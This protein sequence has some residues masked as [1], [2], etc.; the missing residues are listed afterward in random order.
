M[1]QKSDQEFDTSKLPFVEQETIASQPV[2]IF[3]DYLL[4]LSK[5]L[6]QPRRLLQE[7]YEEGIYKTT[8]SNVLSSYKILI[9]LLYYILHGTY[10]TPLA[11]QPPLLKQGAIVPK[12]IINALEVETIF[13]YLSIDLGFFNLFALHIPLNPHKNKYREAYHIFT[14]FSET[15]TPFTAD[16]MQIFKEIAHFHIRNLL[17]FSSFGGARACTEHPTLFLHFDTY[18]QTIAKKAYEY[19]RAPDNGSPYECFYPITPYKFENLHDRQLEKEVTRIVAAEEKRLTRFIHA[20]METTHYLATCYQQTEKAHSLVSFINTEHYLLETI[21]NVP[22]NPYYAFDHKV[23]AKKRKADE[24]KSARFA[25]ELAREA[26]V[27]RHKWEIEYAL[28]QSTHEIT[29]T[30]VIS[31]LP[32]PS[33]PTILGYE[34]IEGKRSRNFVTVTD[35]LR[36]AGMYMVGVGGTGKSSE[37]EALVWQDI[38]K[39][40]GVIVLDPH[41]QLI[42]NII[43]RMPEQFLQKTYFFDLADET[44]MFGLNIFSCKDIASEKERDKAFGGVKVAFSKLFPEADKKLFGTTLR[45][46][47][48]T[49]IENP[50]MTLQ[51][52]QRFIQDEAYREEKIKH[53]HHAQTR[54]YWQQT[55]SAK[56]PSKQQTETDP[57]LNRVD[58]LLSSNPIRRALCQ[59]ATS[60]DFRQAIENREIILVR[61]PMEEDEYRE[62]GSILGTILVSKIKSATFS[63][64]DLDEKVIPGFSLYIDEFQNFES[65]DMATLYTQARKYGVRLCLAHQT[66]KGQITI[67][68]IRA[69]T[70]SATTKLFFRSI[71]ADSRELAGSI[72]NLELKTRPDNI[73]HEVLK[74]LPY[75]KHWK[76]QNFAKYTVAPLQRWQGKDD[77]L[78][79]DRR[80]WY[81]Y[82]DKNNQTV[83]CVNRTFKE[84]L[85]IIEV[86]LRD[87]MLK[88]EV[89]LVKRDEIINVFAVRWGF[90]NSF[91]RYSWPFE[92]VTKEQNLRVWY[93]G[94]DTPQVNKGTE[95]EKL[96][97]EALTVEQ[98]SHI[99]FLE[100][101]KE[102]AEILI[103]DPIG[104]KADTTQDERAN[105]LSNL[106]NRKV[107]AKIESKTFEMETRDLDELS[108]PVPDY[109]RDTRIDRIIDQTHRD[110]CK[111]NSMIDAYLNRKEQSVKADTDVE[112]EEQQKPKQQKKSKQ[113]RPQK[114]WGERKPQRSE[115]GEDDDE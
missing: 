43:A 16:E 88:Q 86:F 20:F 42:K 80:L 82:E 75:Y 26:E 70:I 17:F 61:L 29:D 109:E 107:V 79:G 110:Y 106:P 52:I 55:F 71:D 44:H 45:H 15:L 2:N 104:E 115:V 81:W 49:M 30:P 50:D 63:F 68:T 23:A 39:G 4:H 5:R 90:P 112:Q 56:P 64:S 35:R 7:R 19:Y 98:K 113:P 76:V 95:D 74:Q 22:S 73:P 57:F 99:E 13:C 100:Y 34:V 67:E 48:H 14:R 114:D 54:N 38:A 59:P 46:V 72:S 9:R 12:Q 65:E 10:G 78:V 3:Y 6:K 21:G 27:A 105:Y 41:G 32:D 102:I 40:Y 101:L 66:R 93:K 36:R 58:E 60:I 96:F 28:S 108:L 84:G 33:M 31:P 47:A 83:K 24:I 92:D 8:R 91:L 11:K 85:H 77:E 53:L 87:A 103:A 62:P 111:E 94:F 37:I 97:V 1:E 25:A 18:T 89:D 69:A 51:D